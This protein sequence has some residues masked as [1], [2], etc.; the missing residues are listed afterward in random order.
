MR[1]AIDTLNG[2]DDAYEK[3]GK[4]IH[5]VLDDATAEFYHTKEICVVPVFESYET[6]GDDDMIP[7]TYFEDKDGNGYSLAGQWIEKWEVVED[8]DQ[9][10]TD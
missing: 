2:I 1:R 5:I 7:G 8:D 6:I 4:W 10:T 3:T 9:A